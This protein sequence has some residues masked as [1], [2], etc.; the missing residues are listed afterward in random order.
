MRPAF[1]HRER[2]RTPPDCSDPATELVLT[3]NDD[4]PRAVRHAVRD[5]CSGR[6][7]GCIAD[8]EMVVSELVTN[9]VRHAGGEVVTV[10]L[11]KDWRTITGRVVDGGSGFIPRPRA[12]SDTETGGRG[13]SI[14]DGLTWSWG[15]SGKGA[16]SSVWFQSGMPSVTTFSVLPPSAN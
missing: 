3:S 14:V 7:E 6:D 4:A 10:L 1:V 2:S 12:D 5:L 9:A 15:S 13:L 16:P 11:S 8:A